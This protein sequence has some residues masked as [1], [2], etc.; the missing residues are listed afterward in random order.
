M[1]FDREPSR[2][3]AERREKNSPLRDVAGMLRSF[4]YAAATLA[5]SV[6][7]QVDPRTREIRSARWERDVRDAFLQGYL[8]PGRSSAEA[9]ILPANE[10]HVRQLIALFETD[11]A[12]YELAY[13]LNNRPAWVWIPMRGIAKLFTR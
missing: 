11:K 8:R 7:R 10:Q 5:T 4:S 1:V 9:R 2:A 12:F 6:E 13:E 3:L